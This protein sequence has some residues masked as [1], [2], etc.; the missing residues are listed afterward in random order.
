M[1]SFSRQMADASNLF[2][3]SHLCLP[4]ALVIY[5]RALEHSISMHVLAANGGF[6]S[7]TISD[8]L[9]LMKPTPSM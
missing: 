5:G 4:S 3:S 9:L 7:A 6:P 8:C 2:F 1:L